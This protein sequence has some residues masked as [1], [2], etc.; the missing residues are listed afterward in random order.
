MS[1]KLLSVFSKIN[2]NLFSCNNAIGIPSQTNYFIEYN[3]RREQHKPK[4]R[5]FKT[6]NWILK[7]KMSVQK[8]KKLAFLIYFDFCLHVHN[9]PF[10]WL[11]VICTL[12][13]HSL[14]CQINC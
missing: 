10:S 8:M 9:V 14:D 3:I 11:S 1:I 2:A 4:L 5:K 12:P 7:L 6:I 13:L